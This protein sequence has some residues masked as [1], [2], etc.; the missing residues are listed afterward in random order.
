MYPDTDLPPL[1]ITEK[2]LKK[3]EENVPEQLWIREKKYRKMGVPEHL[4]IKIASSP[5]AEIFEYIIEKLNISPVLGARI[6][7]EKST[8]WKRAGFDIH[9]IS[10]QDWK[11]YF[12]FVS[13]YPALAEVS[14]TIFKNLLLNNSKVKDE[15]VIYISEKINESEIENLIAEANNE[16]INRDTLD[17]LIHKQIMGKVMQHTRGKI[18]GNIVSIR[19]WKALKRQEV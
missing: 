1:E 9:S 16:E 19:I 18:P 8:E 3:L 7:F 14:D 5:K 17:Q 12:T 11:D 10:E 6:L 15:I 4:I 13:D 2:R